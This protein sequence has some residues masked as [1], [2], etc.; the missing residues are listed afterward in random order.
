MKSVSLGK[1]VVFS[2]LDGTLLDASSYSFEEA[3]PGLRIIREREVPLVI[4]SSKTRREIEHYRMLLNNDGPF[5]TENGGGIF[6]PAGYFGS[7]PEDAGWTSER[8]GT[9]EAIRLGTRYDI[10]REALRELRT[11]GFDV[12]GFGD[13]SAEEVAQVTGLLHEQAEMAKERDFDEPF[14]FAGSEERVSELEEAIKKRDFHSRR[15]NSCTFLGAAT[16]AKR[17]GY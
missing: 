9:Y 14:I 4:C 7:G 17:S 15:G 16:K 12:T 5:I 10:L 8:V 11:E 13:M 6:I 3:L 2:D 1:L